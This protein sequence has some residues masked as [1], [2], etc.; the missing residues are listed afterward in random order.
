MLITIDD[1]FT[2]VANHAIKI[3]SRI[4]RDWRASAGGAGGEM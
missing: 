1:G 3:S 4:R 2:F